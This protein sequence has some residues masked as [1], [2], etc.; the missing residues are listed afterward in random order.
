VFRRYNIVDEHDLSEAAALM[1]QKA[2]ISHNLPTKEKQPEIQ[3]QQGV[4]IQ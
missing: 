4:T 3:Q 2:Q 1:D